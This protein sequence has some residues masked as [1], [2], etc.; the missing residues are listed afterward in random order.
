MN[1]ALHLIFGLPIS[2]LHLPDGKDRRYALAH[3]LGIQI[4]V[5]KL[6][7]RIRKTHKNVIKTLQNL[8]KRNLK[9]YKKLGIT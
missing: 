7:K 3:D 8:I 9:T 5:Y 6:R 2:K 1:C 4:L